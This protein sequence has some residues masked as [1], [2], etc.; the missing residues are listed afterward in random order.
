MDT[1]PKR[2][3]DSII[4]LSVGSTLP[5]AFEEWTFTERTEDHE[6]PIE[7]CQLCG[8]ESL[9]YHFEIR[10]SLTR[11]SLLVGSHCILKF[12]LS[13]FED[14]RK[15]SE[16]E[17]KK[18]LTR[19]TQKMQQESCIR[20]LENLARKE[21]NE[22]LIKALDYYRKHHYLTPKFAF[23][24]LWRLNRTKIDYNPSFFKVA[25][26]RSQH[27]DDL[28]GMELS[29]VHVIWPALSSS[30]RDKAMSFGHTPPTKVA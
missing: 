10:N 1:Y 6:Q 21:Q 9:R 20:A 5:E 17:A 16:T 4:P 27:K 18:K 11:A 12:G 15:L 13:V 8:K 2:V 23:V 28:K 30:Q 14:G 19:L 7:T 24:V 29:R 22:I 25:L 26:K 3:R